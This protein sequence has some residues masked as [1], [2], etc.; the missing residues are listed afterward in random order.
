[1]VDKGNRSV[2]IYRDFRGSRVS[3]IMLNA[4]TLNISQSTPNGITKLNLKR[5]GASPDSAGM[6]QATTTIHVITS[7]GGR[8]NQARRTVKLAKNPSPTTSPKLIDDSPSP[9]SQLDKLTTNDPKQ[10]KW[11]VNY[12]ILRENGILKNFSV[13]WLAICADFSVKTVERQG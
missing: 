4:Q 11:Y 8:P 7:A 2:D 6:G 12:V 1:M 3:M 13:D 5:S 10:P 9:I